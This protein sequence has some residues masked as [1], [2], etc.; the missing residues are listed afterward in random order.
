MAKFSSNGSLE[1]M[2]FYFKKKQNP[3]Y[4][5]YAELDA[6]LYAGFSATQAHVHVRT[7]ALRFSG[8]VSSK[9]GHSSWSGDIN[10]GGE[11]VRYAVYEQQRGGNHDFMYPL[12]VTLEQMDEIIRRMD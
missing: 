12:K 11:G 1:N 6:A 10:Y 2:K 4:D 3:P 7:S 5:T 8:G 9:W